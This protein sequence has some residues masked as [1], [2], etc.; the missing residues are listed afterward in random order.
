MLYNWIVKTMECSRE[1]N[2]SN[3]SA[4][5]STEYNIWI[6]LDT[7]LYGPGISDQYPDALCAGYR[8]AGAVLAEVLDSGQFGHYCTTSTTVVPTLKHLRMTNFHAGAYR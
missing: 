3:A 6:Q 1:R 4:S 8:G 5:C 7:S 2:F